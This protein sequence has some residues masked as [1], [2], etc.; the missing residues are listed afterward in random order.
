V[1]QPSAAAASAS[2]RTSWRLAAVSSRKIRDFERVKRM[3]SMVEYA[4][5]MAPSA[6]AIVSRMFCERSS[7]EKVGA[8]GDILAAQLL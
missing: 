8:A 2:R 4:R 6:M 1:A 5:P 7:H 3:M